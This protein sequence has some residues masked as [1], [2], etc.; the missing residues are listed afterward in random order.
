MR[1]KIVISMLALAISSSC[2]TGCGGNY[3]EMQKEIDKQA[4]ELQKEADKQAEELQKKMDN[5]LNGSANPEQE[6][7]PPQDQDD[8]A[9]SE[10]E[11]TGAEEG[12]KPESETGEDTIPEAKSSGTYEIAGEKFFFSDSVNNDVTGKWRISKVNTSMSVEEYASE[13]YKEMFSAD[14]EVHA[15]VNFALST[16]NRITVMDSKTL[17][18]SILE[19]VD[20]E[21]HDAKELF[22]GKVLA[23]FTVDIET[24]KAERLDEN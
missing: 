5:I 4:S 22:G 19:Y 15:V 18:V 1:K 8:P 24:G 16:T 10:P 6:G 13:Y 11:R 20:R 12:V 14:D 7:E 23:E 21:E 9:A 17:D 3:A 2:I